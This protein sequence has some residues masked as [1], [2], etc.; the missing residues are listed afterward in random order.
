[1]KY[2]DFFSTLPSIILYDPLSEF[3][4][5]FENGIVEFNYLDVVKNSGH[6][7][8]TVAGAYLMSLYALNAL[9]KDETPVRGNIQISFR[10][11]ESSGVTGVFA[12]VMSHITGAADSSGFKGIN[13]KF[14]RAD[15]INFNASINAIVKFTRLDTNESVEV[16]YDPSSITQDPK[17]KLWQ[18]KV[19][20]IFEQSDKVISVI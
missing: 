5:T 11:D 19:E 9:Y 6:S 8:P 7:C 2:P 14:K 4:G 16:S 3:L 13:G 1:M 12:N 17:Y 20:K 10:E 18:E 15:L